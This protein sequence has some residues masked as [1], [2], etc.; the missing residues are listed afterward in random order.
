MSRNREGE[1]YMGNSETNW[2]KDTWGNST[3]TMYK[4]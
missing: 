3:Q 1:R 2:E 4:A